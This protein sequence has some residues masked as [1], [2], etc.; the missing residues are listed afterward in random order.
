[1]LKETQRSQVRRYR[2]PVLTGNFFWCVAAV[3]AMSCLT[4]ANRADDRFGP[5]RPSLRPLPRPA[6]AP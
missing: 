6:N 3:I 5:G 4:V 1:M 2:R